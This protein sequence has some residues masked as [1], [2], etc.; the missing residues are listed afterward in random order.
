MRRSVSRDGGTLAVYFLIDEKS[1][2]SDNL[3]W[4]QIFSVTVFRYFCNFVIKKTKQKS[5]SSKNL[6]PRART[7]S[8][9]LDWCI[10][11]FKCLLIKNDR[12]FSLLFLLSGA[13]FDEKEN[14]VTD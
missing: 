1:E 11:C 3:F 8:L 10:M 2:H 6:Y 5:F 12:V 9:Q 7:T 4:E 14:V 13:E